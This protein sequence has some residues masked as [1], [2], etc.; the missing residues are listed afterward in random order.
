M[1]DPIVGDPLESDPHDQAELAESVGL[2]LLVVLEALAP[3]ERL[4]FVLHDMFGVSFEGIVPIVDR[5]PAATRQ[6][7][8]RARRRV[9]GLA[10][11][12]DADLNRQREVV[13]AFLAASRDGD[14]DALL[15]VLDPDVVLRLDRGA[16]PADASKVIRGA[17]NVAKLGF[18]FSGDGWVAIP[19]MVN[20]AAGVVIRRHG[21]AFS[22]IAFTV[23]GGKIATIDILA[24]PARVRALKMDDID[25]SR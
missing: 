4:A 22:V 25:S 20:G 15:A 9:Q 2:A 18:R 12:S 21:R 13:G 1:P 11:A 5:T 8:S 14:F 17:A 16:V 24:D 23:R 10:P 7:A 6:L 19:T 3:A